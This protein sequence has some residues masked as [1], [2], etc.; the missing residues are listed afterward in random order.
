MGRK[1]T[2]TATGVLVINKSEGMT[3]HDVVSCV[4]RLYGTRQ[5]GHT[6]TLDPMATGVLPVLLG[7]TVKASDFV[8]AEEKEYAAELTLGI[9]T[10]TED[11]TGKILSESDN[12]PDEAAVKS[13]CGKFVGEILQTP[14]MYSALKVGGR[15]L[16]DLA[17][18]GVTVE[19]EPRRINV[20][21][22]EPEK[23]SERVY[24][25]RVVCSK[26]TYI[27]TLCAD[28][29][30]ALGCGGAMSALCRTRTGRFALDGAVTLD[31]L[32]KMT[33]EERAALPL[34]T[35]T[36]FEELPAIEL[37]PFF[38]R[39]AKNGCE[40][41]L[42]KIGKSFDVGQTVRLRAGGEFFA[43]G[44]VAAYPDG[45]AVKPVKLFVL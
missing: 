20:N 23:I 12:I 41:Y 24:S 43:L 34:P 10:D 30:R 27:R 15:K 4:R 13:A 17:R 9:T 6:G 3:S 28:I 16:Y 39:L 14:P 8:M 40:I 18:E 29:G 33:P 7:R 21:S 42:K 19:R 22:I 1:H 26:G 32:E 2:A 11:T 36:L 31:E 37:D 25:L 38:A 5:V 44:K 35:E 45:D